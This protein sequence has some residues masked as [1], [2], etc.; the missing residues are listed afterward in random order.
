MTKKISVSF[1]LAAILVG[2]L[3]TGF[4]CSDESNEA[5]YCGSG[6]YVEQ[7]ET[8]N[9]YKKETEEYSIKGNLPNYITSY[10]NTNCANIAGAVIIGYYDRLHENLIPNYKTYTQIGSTIRYKAANTDVQQVISTLYTLMGTNGN[11]SGTTYN[12][13]QKGMKTYVE[14]HGYIY[15]TED[16]GNINF[17]KYKSAV[18][19]EKPVALF[20]SAYSML[21]SCSTTNSTETIVSTSCSVAHVEVGCGYRVDT[22]YNASNQVVSTR[23]YLKVA[24][25][26]NEFNIAYLCLDNNTTIDKA[27]SININ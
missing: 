9:Y 18:E 25:G 3:C 8:I 17:D 12:G 26:L 4:V 13:F 19:A 5:T 2:N 22:Y 27:T 16:L 15:E 7:R 14:N 20:L 11:Q 1:I 10:G 23:A 6:G 21:V 24:S